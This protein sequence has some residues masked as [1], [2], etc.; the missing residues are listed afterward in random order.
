MPRR[1]SRA[2][3]GWSI[4]VDPKDAAAV[5]GVY[6]NA[7]CVLQVLLVFLVEEFVLHPTSIQERCKNLKS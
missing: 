7:L 1:A 2:G 6:P 5:A 4:F 3:T